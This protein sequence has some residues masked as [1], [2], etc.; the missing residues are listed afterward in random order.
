MPQELVPMPDFTRAAEERTQRVERNIN[1][2]LMV[3]YEADSVRQKGL[4]KEANI[5][6]LALPKDEQE[7]VMVEVSSARQRLKNQIKNP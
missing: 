4:Y 5:A 6:L 3:L 2:W 7:E 1:L